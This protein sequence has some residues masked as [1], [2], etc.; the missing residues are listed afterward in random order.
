M[1]N[2]CLYLSL[3]LLSICLFIPQRSQGQSTISCNSDDMGRH[4]CSVDVRGGVR[5]ATR[6]SDAACTEG[7]S[8]GTDERGIWV[9]HGCRADFA[10]GE[11]R[12][13]QDQ[14]A[15]YRDANRDNRDDYRNRHDDRN[16]QTIP[17]N[18]DDERRHSCSFDT[19]SGVRL[20]AQHSE[21]ACTEGYSW[22]SDERGIWVDH[23]CRADFTVGRNAN[24][25]DQS[26]TN[27]D[28]NHDGRDDN[29]NRHDDRNAQTIACNSDDM[30]KHYCR[31]DTRGG[32][33]L[34]TQHSDSACTRGYSW[35]TNKQGIWVDHGCRG[36][37]AVI[38]R[39]HQNSW[40]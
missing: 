10:V 24:F 14:N 34:V 16:T 2:R 3:A 40:R 37:F 8:W 9:D 6:H 32:V 28:V 30:R 1:K 35:G 7:Y 23:G 21:A 31:V 15:I 33:R 18:S 26:G 25:S 20:L 13:G 27:R 29:Q 12:N 36:D 38:T 19:R 11:Y 5:L 39:D 4:S 22:G 17:C